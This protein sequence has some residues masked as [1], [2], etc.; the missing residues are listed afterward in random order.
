MGSLKNGWKRMGV[1]GEGRTGR[2]GKGGEG[3]GERVGSQREGERGGG[4]GGEAWNMIHTLPVCAPNSKIL[5]IVPVF[6]L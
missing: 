5:K 6:H 4:R 3:G 2:M 1:K